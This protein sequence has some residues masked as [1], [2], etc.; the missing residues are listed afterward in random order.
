MNQAAS[1]GVK[2]DRLDASGPAKD[3]KG[4]VP[5]HRVE[6]TAKKITAYFNLDLSQ[7]KSYGLGEDGESFMISLAL[8]KIR[9]LLDQDLRL[10]TACDLEV[11]TLTVKRPSNFELPTEEEIVDNLKTLITKLGGSG[12]FANPAV[13]EVAGK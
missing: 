1:G 2:F 11:S 7:L 10:R 4:H 12:I 6:Y 3:G 8:L 5:F 9:R 13:L